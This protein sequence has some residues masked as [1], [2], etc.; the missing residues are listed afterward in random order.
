MMRTSIPDFLVEPLANSYLWNSASDKEFAKSFM[1]VTQVSSCDKQ[2]ICV[3]LL[4]QNGSCVE[5]NT[6]LLHVPH[7]VLSGSSALQVCLYIQCLTSHAGRRL[8]HLQSVALCWMFTVTTNICILGATERH[9]CSQ[10][11]SKLSCDSPTIEK[12][13]IWSSFTVFL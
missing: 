8:Q 2:E 11:N 7:T 4:N 6:W 9:Y 12:K 5:L 10:S 1:S 13:K 3:F